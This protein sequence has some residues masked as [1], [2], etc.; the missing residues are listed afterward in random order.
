M[1][2]GNYTAVIRGLPM[3]SYKMNI[4]TEQEAALAY[5]YMAQHL[6]GDFANL[7]EVTI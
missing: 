4:A 2:Q 3:R 7:N 6:F 5:N 1:V